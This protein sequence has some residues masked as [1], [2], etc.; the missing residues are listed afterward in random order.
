M[1]TGFPPS[2]YL[3]GAQK[4]GTTFLATMLDQ[5]PNIVLSQPKESDYF[6]RNYHKGQDWYRERFVASD[7]S[8]LVDASTSYTAAHVEASSDFLPMKKSKVDGVPERIHSIA[9]NAQ[10]IYILRDPVERT[11]SSYWHDVR[12]GN[13]KLPFR[14]ALEEDSSFLRISSYAEQLKMYLEYFPREAFQVLFFEDLIKDP[15]ATAR[16]CFKFLGVDENIVLDLKSGKNKSFVY[17]GYMNFINTVLSPL[18]GLNTIVKGVKSFFPEV[19]VTK[20][21]KVMIKDVPKLTNDDREFLKQYF[22]EK[23]KMLEDVIGMKISHWQS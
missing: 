21:A 10:F 18:G 9:P 23:N 6:T 13:E 1:T 7:S 5:H 16:L 15:V 8:I 2:V 11:Y 3:I 17:R 14:K 19:V 4:A 22:K 12:Q 20:L